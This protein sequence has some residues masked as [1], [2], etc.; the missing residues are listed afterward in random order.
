MVVVFCAERSLSSRA[1]SSLSETTQGSTRSDLP[2][3][4]EEM[5]RASRAPGFALFLYRLANGIEDEQVVAGLKD[6][7]EQGDVRQ[8]F[9]LFWGYLVADQQGF[10]RQQLLPGV[11]FP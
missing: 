10:V 4:A 11:G 1:E 5:A 6:R 8:H 7:A 3:M 2:E 9:E